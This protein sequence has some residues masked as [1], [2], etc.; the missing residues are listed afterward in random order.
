M[1]DLRARSRAVVRSEDGTPSQPPSTS[2]LTDPR[3]P[4]A[5]TR[6][7]HAIRDSRRLV[8]VAAQH[9]PVHLVEG[10]RGAAAHEPVV[11][12][13]GG[14]VERGAPRP[15][16]RLRQVSEP[17][18]LEWRRVEL[19]FQLQPPLRPAR[20]GGRAARRVPPAPRPGLFVERE[21]RAALPV[22]PVQPRG[23]D[24]A[25]E[26]ARRLRRDRL[27]VRAAGERVGDRARPR[28][29]RRSRGGRV[30][31]GGGGGGGCGSAS[32]GV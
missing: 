21:P 14:L 1:I 4:H 17:R 9:V 8:A 28:R 3:V 32:R 30:A 7:G 31:A 24:A 19:G 10:G 16:A 2:P 29:H 22:E 5:R 6:A 23:A 11:A 13:R 12:R 15:T 20:R 25:V 26:A 27:E 18:L